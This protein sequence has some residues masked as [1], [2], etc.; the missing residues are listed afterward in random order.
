[1]EWYKGKEFEALSL[2][3]TDHVELLRKLSDIDHKFFILSITIQ[4]ALGAWLFENQDKVEEFVVK[5]GIII[6]DGSLMLVGIHL[7]YLNF[8]RRCEAVITLNNIMDAMG[9]TQPD[10]YLPGRAIN[11]P[12]EQYLPKN[13]QTDYILREGYR[14][15]WPYYKWGVIVSVIGLAFVV[16]GKE[17]M[18][19]F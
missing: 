7:L 4:L 9:Y 18:R 12:Q 3:Y 11:P 10:V 2:R 6:I 13:L 1:M 16:F 17:I 8:I 19:L 15:W 5:C 14:P